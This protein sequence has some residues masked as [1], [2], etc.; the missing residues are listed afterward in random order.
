MMRRIL[1]AAIAAMTFTAMMAGTA[2]ADFGI[3]SFGGEVKLNEAGDPATLAGVH[4]FEASTTVEFNSHVDPT[5]LFQVVPDGDVRSIVVDLPPGFVG[6]PT[7]VPVECTEEQLAVS[8]S[9]KCPDASQVGIVR[10]HNATPEGTA[11]IGTYLP[12]YLMTPSPGKPASFGFRLAGVPVHAD[13]E[14][15]TGSD[16]GITVRVKNIGQGL[17]VLKTAFTFWGVP[18]SPVYDPYRGDCL[19]G[20]GDSQCSHSLGLPLKSFL[21]N[22]MDCSAGPLTTTLQADA[23]GNAGIFSTASF[24][25]DV[26]GVPMAVHDCEALQFPAEAKAAPTSRSADSPTGFDFDLKVSQEGIDSPGALA[27]PPLKRAV[28]TLPQGLSINAAAADGLG[29]CSEDQIGLDSSAPDR[30]P[31]S[32]KVGTVEVTTPLLKD[33]VPGSVFLAQ[34]GTNPFRSLLAMYLVVDDAAR[35]LRIKLPGKVAPDAQTGQLTATFDNNPQLPFSNLEVRFKGGNRA[36]LMTPPSCGTYK[37]TAQ[38]T[39]WSAADPDNPTPGE[40]VTSS[41]SFEITSGPNGQACPNGSFNPKLSAGTTNPVAGEYSPFQLS[42]SRD[43]GTQLLRDLSLTLPKGLTGKLAGIQY[44]P[45]AALAAV[46]GAEGSGAAQIA[47]PSCPAASQVGTVTVGAGAGSNPFYVNTGRAYLAG[48]YK[49]A[50]LSLAV[51]TPAV[52]GPFD[53]GNVVVRSALRVDPASAQIT[54]V[55]DALPTILHGIPLDLRDVRVNLSR[56]RFVLNPTSCGPMAVHSTITSAQGATADPS[57]RF[58][59]GSCERLAFKPSL[60]LSIKGGHKRGAYQRLKAVLSAKPGE[61]NIGKVSVALPHSQFLAQE[62]ILTVCTRVQ[63]A[64][65]QCPSGSIYGYAKAYTPL[66]DEPLQGPVYLRSSDHQLPDLVASLDGQIHIDLAGSIDSVRGGIRNT[67][68]AVP[69][70][71]VS[72]FVLEMKGGKK[73]LLVN[74][75]DTCKVGAGRAMVKMDGQNGKVHDFR[76]ALRT[77]CGGKRR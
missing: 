29:V 1:T 16:Y 3:S 38:L 7:A 41:S 20:T 33:P 76:S 43:D 11:G 74:S 27:T 71:P 72:K 18:A 4:P 65:G 57:S 62:H 39:P 15:R 45:D 47:S 55:S 9:P 40:V 70:A 58:Q 64:A 75:R 30:C 6:N 31:T 48:P 50:P 34:Q 17:P 5:Q 56:D 2:H 59:V 61:A 8:Q 35:G 24:D 68:A 44:C 63:Y 54:A 36:P 21:T 12:V 14:V 49:G 19:Q 46:S 42:L 51:V 77:S 32:S 53:L 23:W 69:D 52:A 25:E 22:P 73:S 60:A 10:V 13:A 37:T 67:F 28:V 26:N 66:L